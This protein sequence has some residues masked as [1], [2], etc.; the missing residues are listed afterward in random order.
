MESTATV[1]L[2]YLREL[3]DFKEKMS[4]TENEYIIVSTL[5]SLNKTSLITKDKVSIEMCKRFD[6]L[7][8]KFGYRNHVIRQLINKLKKYPRLA[9]WI[10][11]IDVKILIY[12]NQ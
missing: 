2:K 11:K 3:E 7:Y 5:F 10:F 9:K 1:P 4:S 12:E 6:E 8:Q